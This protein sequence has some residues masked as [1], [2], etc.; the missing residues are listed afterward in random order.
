MGVNV[1]RLGL[2]IAMALMLIAQGISAVHSE[3]YDTSVPDKASGPVEN[4][5][6]S[7][8]PEALETLATHKILITNLVFRQIFEPYINPDNPVFITSDT[9]INA[10]YV[11][12][13]AS[14]TRFEEANARKLLSVLKLIWSRIASKKEQPAGKS[15]NKKFS[16][17]HQNNMKN[18]YARGNRTELRQA[19][20]ERAQIVIAVAIKLLGDTSIELDGSLKGVVEKEVDRVVRAEGLWMPRWLGNP[21]HGFEALNY[22]RYKPQGIYTHT[23]TLERYF[24]ALSWLQSIPFRVDNDKELLAILLLGKTFSNRYIDDDGKGLEIEKWFKCYSEIVGQLGD[25][26][27]LLASQIIRGRPTDLN[28]V[29]EFLLKPDLKLEDR[30][31]SS[32]QVLSQ[33]EP[34]PV[35]S[36]AEF[37]IISPHR[38]P[39]AILFRR[40]TSLPDFKRNWP[41]GLEIC[42][43]L[44]SEFA[45]E[46]LA[47]GIPGQYRDFLIQEID[48]SNSFFKTNSFYNKY[49]YCLA[50]LIDEPEPDAPLFMTGE[51]WKAKSCSSTLAGWAQRRHPWTFPA[52]SAVHSLGGTIESISSGFVEPEP[53]FFAR[54]GELV[55]RTRDRFM[56]CGAF[57]PPGDLI[58]EDLRGFARLIQ[59]FRYP[60]IDEHNIKLTIEELSILKRSMM[61]LT[62]LSDFRYSPAEISERRDVIISQIQEMAA[63]VEAGEFDDDPAYQGLI[64]DT[65]VDTNALW[66]L[67]GYICRRLEVLA[68]K[69][70]RGVAFNKS[71][72]LFLTDFGERLATVMLYGGDSY[73]S[74]HNDTPL[75]VDVY[76]NPRV[77]GHLHVGVA[78]PRELLVL[79]PQKDGEVLCRGAVLSYYEFVSTKR[80]TDVE[81]RKRL[82]SDER[83]HNPDWLMPFI[84]PGDPRKIEVQ[85]GN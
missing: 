19:A 37:H 5:S 49:L 58:A 32:D 44:G 83:P 47:A 30:T 25:W 46:Q 54:M 67:L 14:I 1:S 64:L 21:T 79:Y 62:I 51:A 23:E 28:T 82:D 3:T 27:L 45:I 77:G 68:H 29:R 31:N 66:Q 59:E 10:F 73:R 39:D 18:A 52:K 20:K 78:R 69:Q 81:W 34:L 11:L 2:I 72:E 84:A 76:S 70:L 33:P 40:T 74:P 36:Q 60:Q 56:R 15:R 85:E 48:A 63:Q 42:T 50:A 43:I 35:V 17:A 16:K 7:V 65:N 9:V 4:I 55:E 22:S 6:S 61:I 71:E 75:I 24:R 38:V 41:T 12:Y 57:V 26:D 8:Q 13:N 53:E 80:L